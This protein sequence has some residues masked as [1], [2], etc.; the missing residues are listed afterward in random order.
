MLASVVSSRMLRHIARTEGIQY[1]DTLTGFKWL[2]NKT[3]ELRAKGIP[4]LFSYEEALGYCI[5]DV[6][7]DKDGVCAG[8]IFAELA[9]VLDTR[10]LTVVQHLAQ[11]YAQYG[12]F[13]SY[14]SY[15]ICRDPV[16]TDAIFHRIRTGGPTGSYWSEVCGSKITSIQDVTV[17]YNSTAADHK[18][19]LPTTPD[20]HMIMF[21]FDNGVTCTFRTSGTEPKI[22]FYTEIAGRP[23]QVKSE[24]STTLHSFVD[25]L[26]EEFLQPTL[27]GLV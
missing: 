14:N 10:N 6:V 8:A 3:I 15:I 26:V 22:K 11:L 12:E 13:V 9:A 7:S 17:G 1:Y 25:A 20:S 19:E 27:N 21:D 2:G 4:V 5:S 23:G 24:L 16:K 18:C